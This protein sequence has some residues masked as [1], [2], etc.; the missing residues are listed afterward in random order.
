[1]SNIM[2]ELAAAI[3]KYLEQKQNLYANIK[4]TVFQQYKGDLQI[5]KMA[6]HYQI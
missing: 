3:L 1:M 4:H 5:L 6:I 2:N